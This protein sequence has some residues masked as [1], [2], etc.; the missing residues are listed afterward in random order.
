MNY[1]LI[2]FLRNPLSVNIENFKMV[3]H[4]YFLTLC[5]GFGIADD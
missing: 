4:L 2:V 1:A 5:N 3:T